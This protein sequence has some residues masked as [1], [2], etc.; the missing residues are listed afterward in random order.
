MTKIAV[1]ISGQPRHFKIGHEYLSKSLEGADVDYFSHLWF[2]KDDVGKTLDV[3]ST[4]QVY[5]SDTVRKDTD[6]EFLSLYKPKS[7][8]FEK[9]IEF[10]DD[11]GLESNNGKPSKSAQPASI[12]ISMLY[13]RWK[14]GEL[15]KDYSAKNNIQYDF[16]IWGR[17]DFALLSPIMDE[18]SS[19][20]DVYTPYV[21]GGEWGATHLN[22]AIVASKPENV[23]HFLN[24]YNT[25]PELYK[26]GI[27]YCDHRMS[28]QQM[29]QLN[30]GF[31]SILKNNWF[32]IRSEGLVPG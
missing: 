26:K 12:F 6:T 2:D 16:M 24:L 9:Q 30:C 17:T 23:L 22:T 19:L 8:Q 3:Y 5:K 29:K 10:T 25:Y 15:M 4:K 31:G 28:F 20:N 13:S 32:W 27:D 1:C 11:L 21:N 14:S 18:V 7:H